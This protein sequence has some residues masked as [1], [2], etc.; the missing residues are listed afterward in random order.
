MLIL[1]IYILVVLLLLVN[2]K[3]KFIFYL[4]FLLQLA[5]VLKIMIPGGPAAPNS[6]M[7][8]YSIIIISLAVCILIIFNH[9]SDL[10]RNTSGIFILVIY[11]FIMVMFSTD[12]WWSFKR[13][14][15]V[16]L[17]FL[18]FPAAF[19]LVKDFNDIKKILKPAI[20]LILV[21]LAN[22]AVSTYLQ[23]ETE[24]EGMGYEKSFI[25]L[26]SVNFYSIYNFVYALILIPL[27]YYFTRKTHIEYLLIILYFIGLTVMILNLKR[28]YVYLT[29]AG[30]LMFI[31]LITKR[32]NVRFIGPFFIIGL[33]TYIFFS[34]FILASI[35]IR[36]DVLR[37]GYA[38]EGRGI[39][40]MLYPEIVSKSEEPATFALFGT[41]L[42]NSQGKFPLIEKVLNDK[43]RLLHSD[44]ATILYGAGIIGMFLFIR[45][46]YFMISKFLKYRRML[47]R[48]YQDEMMNKL[49]ATFISVFICL[50]INT[51]SDGINIAGNRALPY[52][53]LG[54]ILGVIYKT[55][56]QQQ[57]KTQNS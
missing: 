20:W 23:L 11:L 18:V 40:L 41:E 10:K 46:Y 49:Y 43:D 19:I 32:K 39:E 6:I 26:G 17:A 30:A 3:Y 52:L 29:I 50:V 31:F 57:Y 53:I 8:D 42:F 36:E 24:Q 21:F 38:E 22:I 15:N 37:R 55:L 56:Q 13:Y 16:A 5:D 33:I 9:V 45:F 28:T 27:A 4:P 34:D 54:A 14:M 1:G 51:L 35:A 44:L 2:Q 48:I 7:M 12:I 47:R 25:Y